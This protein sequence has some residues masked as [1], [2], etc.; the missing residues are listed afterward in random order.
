[1]M[2]FVL[3]I[4]IAIL[5]SAIIHRSPLWT[6]I[7]YGNLFTSKTINNK[8]LVYCF[9]FIHLFIRRFPVIVLTP[10]AEEVFFRGF[11]YGLLRKDIGRFWGLI[12]QSLIFSLIHFDIFFSDFLYPFLFRFFLGIVLGILFEI[13]KSIY[14][15][16]IC[17]GFVN[18]FAYIPIP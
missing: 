1:M 13:T 8:F 5:I 17:H 3:G 12:V 15:A 7:S 4:T 11:I 10:L 9:F 14:P 6:P 2:S 18:F 16:V